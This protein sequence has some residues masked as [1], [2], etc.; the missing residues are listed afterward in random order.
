MVL[1]SIKESPVCVRFP[2]DNLSPELVS[3]RI[4]KNPVSET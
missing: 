1:F 3:D 4:N 2:V